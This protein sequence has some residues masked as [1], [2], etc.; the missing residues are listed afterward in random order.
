VDGAVTKISHKANGGAVKQSFEYTYNEVYD[1]DSIKH[2][3][4]SRWSYTY[5]DRYRLST[6]T[7]SNGAALTSTIHA[8][9]EYTYDDAD[10]LVKKVTPFE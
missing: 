6:A 7:R 1:I 2:E 3:D 8:E 5:D 10:N 4:G 9:Y